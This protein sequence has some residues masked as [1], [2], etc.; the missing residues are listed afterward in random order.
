VSTKTETRKQTLCREWE[1]LEH[2]APNGTAYLKPLPS[3]LGE[4]IRK[5]LLFL[6]VAEIVP[7][8]K[9]KIQNSHEPYT[10]PYLPLFKTEL[11]LAWLGCILSFSWAED[12]ILPCSI[13]SI[14]EPVLHGLEEME[15]AAN[16]PKC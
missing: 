3:I 4:S 15:Q 8:R 16:V 9:K 11:K 5:I 12:D 1:A 10:D 7:F 6:R 2:S 13:S 14:Q